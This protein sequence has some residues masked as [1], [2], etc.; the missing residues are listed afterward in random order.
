M[1]SVE[2][3]LCA[4]ENLYLSLFFH[5]FMVYQQ[6]LLTLYIK[7]FKTVVIDDLILDINSV[8]NKKGTRLIII[9]IPVRFQVIL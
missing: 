3:F 5:L 8:P 6:F 9:I 7:F 4:V 2:D 1:F